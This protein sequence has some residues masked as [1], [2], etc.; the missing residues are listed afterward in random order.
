MLPYRCPRA[1][2]VG[3][4]AALAAPGLFASDVR[5]R[6]NE[7][8]MKM[9]KSTARPMSA[10]APKSIAVFPGD[11]VLPQFVDGAGWKTTVFLYNMENT[12]QHVEFLFIANNGDDLTAD[13]AGRGPLTGLDLTLKPGETCSFSTLGTNAKN[14]EGWA[15][16]F[17]DNITAAIGMMAVFGY[18]SPGNPTFEAVVPAG[19]FIESHFVLLYDNRAGYVAAAAVANTDIAP[20]TVTAIVRDETGVEIARSVLHYTELQHEAFLVADKFPATKGHAGSIEFIGESGST[21][22]ALGLRANPGGGFTSVHTLINP[23]WF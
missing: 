15:V 17:P 5:T 20:A 3:L 10:T 13:I 19:N 14:S 2:L 11:F 4:I 12:S 18:S 1:L 7:A 22:T 16:M 8:K 6:F 23:D 21:I 9:L